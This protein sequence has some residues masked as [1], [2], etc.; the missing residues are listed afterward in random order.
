MKIYERSPG[1]EVKALAKLMLVDEQELLDKAQTVEPGLTSL[2]EIG[3]HTYYYL[4]GILLGK[5]SKAEPL[6]FEPDDEEIEEDDEAEED[7]EDPEEEE[8]WDADAIKAYLR[9]WNY[10]KETDMA[11][12]RMEREGRFND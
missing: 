7:D 5:Q 12:E 2:D 4:M 3:F 9:D 1:G 11:I 10:D 8:P 6:P